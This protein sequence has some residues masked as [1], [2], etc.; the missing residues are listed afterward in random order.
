MQTFREFANDKDAEAIKYI[1]LSI[2]DPNDAM[3]DS[4]K[5]VL[6]RPLSDFKDRDALLTDT[7]MTDIINR[8]KNRGAIIAA[9]NS[10]NT[11]IGNLVAMLTNPEFSN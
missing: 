6:T 2:I 10:N 4:S 9:I 8:R 11:T 3:D 5:S 1:I 7:A